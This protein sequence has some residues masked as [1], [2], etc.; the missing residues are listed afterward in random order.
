M[1]Y[2]KL[3][4]VNPQKR[5]INQAIEELR[6]GGVIVYPTDSA[7]ALG[8]TLDNRAGVEKMRQIRNLKENHPLTWA[9]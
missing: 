1:Q 2:F 7:Y 3:H 9:A 5:V 6:E 8:C 4:A